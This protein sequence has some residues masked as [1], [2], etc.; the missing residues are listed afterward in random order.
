MTPLLLSAF[1][2]TSCLGRGLDAT[3]HALRSSRS[4]LAPCAFE[5][6]KL[7]TWVGEV[8]GV[9]DEKLPAALADYDC[10]NNRLTRM[11]LETDGFG[12]RV[13]EAIA[14]HGK[15][16]VGVFLGTSTAG[17]LQTEL[18]YRRRDPAT[19]ALPDDFNY[20]TTH[21]SFSLTEFTRAYFGL[22]GMAMTIS[23][24]CSS[25]AKVFAAAAR[26]IELGMIDAAIVGGV[27]TLCLT[28]LYGFASLQLT[29]PQPCRPYD[30]A[31]DGISIGEGAGFALLERV[32]GA[33][34]GSVLLLGA[35]ES[36]DAYHM[37]SPHPQGLGAKLAME[38]ALKSA[39]LAPD[40]IDY[41]NLHGTATPAND[42]AEGT[43]VAALFGGRAPCSSTKGATGHT[44]GAA[45]AI[46]AVICALALTDGLLPGSPGTATPD[47][48]IPVQYLLESR[49]S[50][51]RR[52]LSNSFGFGGSNCS[53]VFGVAA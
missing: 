20:R 12:D 41:I 39:G 52:V 42:A 3:R 24:A 16:R 6:V 25:S 26:Q 1:T 17:I 27:D 19:G 35:G 49:S 9:D 50:R 48:A 2:A 40:D 28:T 5:T 32:A 8:A 33:A 47:P 23:T 11:G 15:T 22:E 46:E 13:R 21:N 18:A 36:S 34:P 29:S 37:S 7:D 30:A 44:L 14:R 31:R 4:G 38:A 43:A 45:G 51:V 53:L 10:R